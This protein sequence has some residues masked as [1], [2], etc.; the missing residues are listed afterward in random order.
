MSAA[1]LFLQLE[2]NKLLAIVSCLPSP[3]FLINAEGAIEYINP[4]AENLLQR[5]RKIILGQQAADIIHFKDSRINDAISRCGGILT[6]QNMELLI[7]GSAP[8]LV[9]LSMEPLDGFENHTILSLHVQPPARALVA[10]QDRGGEQAAIGAPSIL[11]HEIKNPL[12]GI[13]GAAQLLAKKAD[14]RSR[15]MLSLIV[16]EVDRIARI[17]DEIQHLGSRKPPNLQACNIHVLLDR[18]IQSLRAANPHPPDIKINFDPSLPDV[19]VDRDAMLQIL[20]NLLQNAT[21]ALRETDDR[22]I[23]VTTRFVMSGAL[24]APDQAGDARSVKL[25]VE[26]SIADNG[27]GVPDHIKD[28]LFSP[29]VTT[30]RDGQGLGLAIVQ[31]LVRD[32][33]ARVSYERSE[34]SAQ[35]VFRLML[36]VEDWRR[37]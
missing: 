7:H 22:Q 2:P 24:R 13:K 19:I 30:K 9:D 28:E 4:A 21:D 23:I 29:F 17:I 35:T 11:S 32:M 33:N 36:P 8:A 31:K 12:A 34:N 16:N 26:I 18:A 37:P 20:I 10:A 14:E 3:I 25:P 6:A 5:S 1:P 27:A 15:P